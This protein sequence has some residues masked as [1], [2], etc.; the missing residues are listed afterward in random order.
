M[1]RARLNAADR[2]ALV[3]QWRHSG[4]SL[5]AF[6][7]RHGINLG[8]MRGWV[9]KQGHRLALEQAPCASHADPAPDQQPPTAAFLPVRLV[10][11][12]APAGP[13]VE[14]VLGPGRRVVVAPGFDPET[15]RRVIAVLEG[16]PC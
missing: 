8:T 7:Q 11:P 5:P 14:V 6:C 16:R 4:L 3:G 2:A 15:L 1:S 9:Y 13:G 10:E 12:I